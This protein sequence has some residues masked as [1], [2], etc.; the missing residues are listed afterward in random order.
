MGPG[1]EV[2]YSEVIA[3]LKNMCD[4]NIIEAQ[5]IAEPMPQILPVTKTA[6]VPETK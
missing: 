1:L 4:S 5:F 2:A 3:I 6:E